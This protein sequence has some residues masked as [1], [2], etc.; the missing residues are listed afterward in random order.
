MVGLAMAV[1]GV[2]MGLWAIV[3]QGDPIPLLSVWFVIVGLMF[4]GVAMLIGIRD[5]RSSDEQ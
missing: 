4:A 1:V 5:K 2:A 3:A